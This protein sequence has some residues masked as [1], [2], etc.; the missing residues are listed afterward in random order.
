MLCPLYRGH[1]C[2]LRTPRAAA[3]QT[4]PNHPLL[5]CRCCDDTRRAALYVLPP[6]RLTLH[7]LDVMRPADWLQLVFKFTQV[8]TFVRLL[9]P[10]MHAYGSGLPVPC[11]SHSHS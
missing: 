7:K 3:C 9:G 4:R 8:C 2:A 5:P 6:T 11:V 10:H 1:M